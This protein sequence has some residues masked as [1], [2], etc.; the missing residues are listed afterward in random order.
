VEIDEAVS[1]LGILSFY[2][3]AWRAELA[4]SP[5]IEHQHLPGLGRLDLVVDRFFGADI[6]SSAQPCEKYRRS[7][8]QDV[9]LD[10]LRT[11]GRTMADGLPTGIK[12]PRVRNLKG[13]PEAEAS[14]LHRDMV[15]FI[16]MRRGLQTS[17]AQIQDGHVKIEAS[18]QLLSR[19]KHEGF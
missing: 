19:I 14:A 15:L 3:E 12:L 9:M 17:N 8:L 18:L 7:P 1:N 2:V 10:Q 5:A 6:L 4:D 11:W 13:L 16:K